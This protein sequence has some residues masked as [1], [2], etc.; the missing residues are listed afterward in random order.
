VLEALRGRGNV[1]VL[2]WG[3]ADL[4]SVNRAY[5]TSLAPDDF[6]WEHVGPRL[7]RVLGGLPLPLALLRINLL[8][9][10][11]RALLR[12]GSY[13]VVLSTM[14]ETDVGVPAIQYIHYPWA[15]FPRPDADYRW[16]HWSFPLRA[17][18]ALA[19]RV[20]GYS[21]ERVRRNLTFVNSDWTGRVF[22]ACYGVKPTTLYPP[23]PGGFPA[24]P[25]E[26]REDAFVCAGRISPEKEIE[27]V[28]AIL[29]RVRARGHALRLR[30]VGHEDDRRYAARVRRAAATQGDWISF[31]IDLSRDEL[32]RLLARQRYGIH[33]MVGEHF[34]IAP[35]EMLRAGCIP[36]VPGDGGTEEIV[37]G[38]ERLIY[39]SPDDAVEKIDRV[40]RDAGLR[41]ALRAAL[42]PRRELLSEQHF[43]R[44]IRELV[45]AP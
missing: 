40:L 44:R 43:V 29:A 37:G 36:F 30:I 18:R 7:R 11:A 19:A 9:R 31:H 14:N 39:R 42:E 16:Y 28:I 21:A 38:D 33:G 5:G 15:F 27:K 10:R 4:A 8:L 25:W 6:R 2:T 12:R 35:A 32:V 24:V 1:T 41:A 3:P 23:V 26:E 17:Y 45:D 34:G 20:S 13:D 22:E